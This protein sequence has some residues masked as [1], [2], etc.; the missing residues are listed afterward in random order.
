LLLY[1]GPCPEVKQRIWWCPTGILS[2]LPIHAAGIHTSDSP[3]GSKLSDFVISSYTPTVT[4]LIDSNVTPSES[5]TKPQLLAVAQPTSYGQPVIPD[6]VNEIKRIESVLSNVISIKTLAG[7]NATLSTVV[8]GLKMS[9]WAHFA[10]HGIQDP[11]DPLQSALLV[12]TDERLTLE[13][14]AS[15]KR[16]KVGGLAFLS[17]S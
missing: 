1:Q 2:A 9:N 8:K 11:T 10:C 17:A 13:C 16:E 15:I 14:I 4:A 5:S 6:T 12:G 3:I 7:S